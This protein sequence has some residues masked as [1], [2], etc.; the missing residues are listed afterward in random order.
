VFA[1]EHIVPRARGG[2]SDLDNLALACN[3]CNLAK[4]ARVKGTDPRTGRTT[5]LYSPRADRWSDHFTWAGDNPTLVGRSA[6][7]RATIAALDMNSPLR[8]TARL[9]WRELDLL[10]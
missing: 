10:P 6:I 2:T 1:V 7:G 8:L 4:G 3:P 5:R 9:L